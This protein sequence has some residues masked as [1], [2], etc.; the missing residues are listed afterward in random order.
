MKLSII[1][2]SYNQKP[3][4]SKMLDSIESQDYSNYEHI[5]YD[6]GSRDGSLDLLTD[7]AANKLNVTLEIGRD[8]GQTNAINSGFLDARGEIITW[9]NTDDA[10]F[11]KSV[12]SDV[13]AVFEANPEIDIV[14]G[15]GDFVSPEGKVLKKAFINKD[16]SDLKNRFITSLGILQ[17]A[18]FMRKSVF[19]EIGL[20]DEKMDFSFDYEYWVRAFFAGKKFHFIDRK[21]CTATIHEDAKT[22]RDRLAS[23]RDCAKVCKKYYGFVAYEWVDRLARCEISG[24]DGILVN[25]NEE[26][27]ELSAKRKSL[28]MSLNHQKSDIEMA[29]Q[30]SHLPGSSKTIEFMKSHMMPNSLRS[31]VTTFD[32]LYF[33][34]GLTMISGVQK[35]HGSTIPIFVYAL[36]IT[37][38]QRQLLSTLSNVF[39]IDFPKE[40]FDFFDGY[41]KPKS[42]GFKCFIMWHIEHF[43]NK[44]D[45]ALWVDAGVCPVASLSTIFDKISEDKVFFINHGDKSS[46]FLLNLVLSTD[47]C[48]RAMGANNKELLGVQLR[49]SLMGYEIQGKYQR[50]FREAF[51]YSLN[52][53]AVLGD[54][55][56]SPPIK[57]DVDKERRD[58][59]T[60]AMEEPEFR[61]KLSFSE[62]RALFPYFGHR[63]DQSIF[64]ILAARYDAPLSDAN[65]YCVSCS[66]SSKA[67]RVN[68]DVQGYSEDISS[69]FEIPLAYRDKKTTTIQHR[70]LYNNFEGLR[71]DVRAPNTRAVIMGNG[72]SLKGFDFNRLSGLD[73]FGMNA[74]YRYWDEISWYPKYYSCLDTVV[75]L[76]HA[77]EI[78]RLIEQSDEN[79]IELFLLRDNLIS[80]FGELSN[81]HKVINF[82]LLSDG[83]EA[84]S[85][86]PVTTGSHTLAW[87]VLLGYEECFLMGIDCD[88]T[89]QIEGAKT[90]E[91]NELVIVK[92]SENPNYF[93]DG[94]QRVGD[95]YNV[96]NPNKDLHVRSW[97]N[98]ADVVRPKGLTILNAN[99]L[100]K[101]DAFDFCKFE[102][103]EG[104]G[105]LEIIKKQVLLGENVHEASVDVE[106]LKS[107][108]AII[109]GNG[110][111]LKGFDFSRFDKFT[112]FGM[113]AAYRYWD[114]INWYPD[115]YSCLDLAVGLSHKG[116]IKRLI[117]NSDTY[118]IKAFLLRDNLITK[119]GKIRNLNRVVNFDKLKNQSDF[120]TP[121][122]ITTGSHTAAWA[123]LLGFK[124]LF[125]MGVDCNYVGMVEGSVRKHGIE[126]KIREEK[127]NPNY[128]FEGYQKKGDVYN[129]P[130]P[131]HDV[132]LESWRQIKEA[133]KS[134]EVKILNSNFKSKVD[135]FDFCTFENVESGGTIKIIDKEDVLNMSTQTTTKKSP[136]KTLEAIRYP[137][138]AQAGFDETYLIY[139]LLS[140][141]DAGIMIDVGAHFG[142]SARPFASRGWSVFCQEPD[143]NNREKLVASLGNNPRVK[144]DTRAVGEI[145]EKGR[146]FYSSD[147]S[148][149]IS[150]MLAFRDTHKE[151][152][153]VDVTTVKDIIADNKIDH[154]DF[155]KIDVEGYDFGVLKGVPWD[156]MKPDIIECEFED[157]KTKHLGHSWRDICEYLK[158]LG[159]TV[160]VSEWHPIIRYGISHDWRALK[161]YPC[162]LD[163]VNAWGNLLAFKNDP[164]EEKLHNTLM[165]IIKLKNSKF[166]NQ[167]APSEANSNALPVS[168]PTGIV[169]TKVAS[170]QTAKP[171]VDSAAVTK[172]IVPAAPLT[173]AEK[174]RQKSPALFR[175]AQLA[176]WGVNF[177]RRHSALSLFAA[178]AISFLIIAPF[179]SSPLAPF[180]I[181][182]WGM[183][184]LIIL[185]GLS[186]I[187][188]SFVNMMA[189]R[190]AERELLARQALKSDLLRSIEIENKHNSSR[191]QTIEGRLKGEAEN[192]EKLIRKIAQESAKDQE[193]KIQKI[194]EESANSVDVAK[195]LE[196]RMNELKLETGA[197]TETTREALELA[198]TAMD[199]VEE[200]AKRNSTSFMR[201]QDQLEGRLIKRL[202]QSENELRKTQKEL[203]ATL[204]QLEQSEKSFKTQTEAWQKETEQKL[205]VAKQEFAN[206]VAT[207]EKTEKDFETKT[208]AWKQETEKRLEAT[209]KDL[210]NAKVKFD[211]SEIK[212]VSH[213][214]FNRSLTQDQ[215][216]HF[217]ENW[218]K[219]LNLKETDRS[220]AYIANRICNI[221][222]NFKGRLATS[223]ENAVLRTLVAKAANGNTLKVLEIGVLFGVGL[224]MLYDRTN[225]LFEKVHITALDPFEGYYGGNAVDILTQER[226]TKKVFMENMATARIPSESYTV[227]EGYS[228]DDSVI[229]AA[230]KDAYDI[231]IID[232]DHSY[233]GVKADFVNYAPFVKRG[234]YILIDD[235]FAP[236]WPEITKYVDDELLPREDIA[237]IGR[238]FRTAV[239]KVIKKVET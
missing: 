177:A 208:G 20:L 157:A 111:S 21:V 3:F 173:F 130:N 77:K 114:Q 75:G 17:P 204:A 155:L 188:F 166:N 132:H 153:T 49:S 151:S 161:R 4:I 11:D 148:T 118:G 83:V 199:K 218:L 200:E 7:Y 79:G 81:K 227:I 203:A 93:F 126:L 119:L 127:P 27:D 1:T 60:M 73:V 135:A 95:K 232:G 145:A 101:V 68:W 76:S 33:R 170:P 36:G 78:Q 100:S 190:I 15:C 164:G 224:A 103:I 5:I 63:Q 65:K 23:L 13:M 84:F 172:A 195:R 113:N 24:E 149:G 209:Q 30:V 141:K 105:S 198:Q 196:S 67:S 181:L 87:A 99:L 142:S 169:K 56:P 139:R 179:V 222:Q 220:L 28:F 128:F 91:G 229:S 89:E 228:T 43:L 124:N 117:E 115:Y 108:P 19:S 71:L 168:S 109:I 136:A 31:V 98:I 8:T 162:E 52:P 180:A 144:I 193:I 202:E 50:L 165:A 48:C 143:S 175:L 88:Y 183:A 167:G 239:F 185:A 205:N 69:S 146:V 94:Y 58:D 201:S 156:K 72:P 214:T 55:H 61:D 234:G 233:A 47:E 137:R 163:D 51:K 122:T 32:A 230:S 62:L 82:D 38:A 59:V 46:I 102:S 106:K 176:K 26:S 231:L 112:T 178:I 131:G 12:L 189:N 120:L 96:P 225:D 57:K 70:G 107:Q 42:Y 92:D 213:Q 192:Q 129:V 86:G 158:N 44:G 138:E 150:G 121:P 53:L 194:S 18:L 39:V 223:I 210:E 16:P 182:F 34:Q 215:I 211:K 125:L 116:Q 152:A 154:V 217:K 74:A 104:G 216:N 6:G 85:K 207:R 212:E 206:H 22:M 37:Q 41:F 66:E 140:H 80:S 160:Y 90:G 134:A 97:R 123:A 184:A 197:A 147:E 171:K 219:P 54:K 236:E 133:L 25:S 2:P 235:D 10:Y 159:Y 237:L 186:V 9:L 35:L 45:N 191:I 238:S 174:L 221:E 187:G 110:P 226:V 40:D 64:S 29:L 14:Y